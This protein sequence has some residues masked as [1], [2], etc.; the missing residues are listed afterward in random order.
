MSTVAP[1]ATRLV[2]N[3]GLVDSS[4][5]PIVAPGRSR[6][7]SA[8]SLA[9]GLPSLWAAATWASCARFLPLTAATPRRCVTGAAAARPTRRCWEACLCPRARALG[10]CRLRGPS[11]P[12]DTFCSRWGSFLLFW[13]TGLERLPRNNTVAL[14]IP[15]D[16]WDE[17]FSEGRKSQGDYSTQIRSALDP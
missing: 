14:S 4:R 10:S 7:V 2:A 6:V 16:N 15:L 3:D 17:D 9:R 13:A 11:R 8:A 5:L 1:P 12:C